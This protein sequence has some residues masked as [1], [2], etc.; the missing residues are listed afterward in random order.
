MAGGIGGYDLP[1][2]APPAPVKKSGGM[3]CMI[4]SLI[5]CGALAIVIIL[6]SAI[7]IWQ[8]SKNPK[9]QQFLGGIQAAAGPCSASLQQAR[10]ALKEYAEDH[11]GNYPSNLSALVPDYLP[12]E[13]SL[14]CSAD[15]QSLKM[16]YT[17]PTPQSSSDA[18]VISIRTGDVQ[19]LNQLQIYHV[20]LLKDGRIVLDQV[21]RTSLIPVE[22]AP[23]RQRP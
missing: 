3:S 14:G 9:T 21:V 17:R 8:V 4:L 20:R 11:D 2:G 22:G 15:S 6:I 18:I 19:L 5:G 10:A 16:E 12:N 23:A 13:A 1:G 7:G